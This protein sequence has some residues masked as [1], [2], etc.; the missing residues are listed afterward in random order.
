MQLIQE[1]T[2]KIKGS[3][4]LVFLRKLV[5]ISGELK[6]NPNWLLAVMNSETAG[7]FS[8]SVKNPYGGATGLIQFMPATAEWL[9]TSTTA[10][11]RM[12]RVQQLDF[13][14][15]YY[16]LNIRSG[17]QIKTYEDLYLITFYPLSINKP[18]RYI[19]GSEVSID[20][21]RT[22]AKYNPGIDIDKNGFI[23]KTEFRQFI[24]QTKIKDKIS[25]RSLRILKS[26][27][28]E[29]KALPFVLMTLGFTVVVGG[30]AVY[31]H[32][33]RNKNASK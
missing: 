26:K 27:A 3:D 7:T 16:L 2:D 4:K 15:K 18:D 31:N 20:R 14:K 10:L 22:V 23:T 25:N 24:Y 5:R 11:S 17:Y 1:F 30:S 21:A 13:V 12:T 32:Y 29:S 9:G 6:I 19:F 33:R 8:A 28:G